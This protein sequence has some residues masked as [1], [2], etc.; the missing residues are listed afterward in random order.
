[1]DSA[2]QILSFILEGDGRF[3]ENFSPE[4]KPF[5]SRI[6]PELPFETRFFTVILSEDGTTSFV[7]TGKIV[8]VSSETATSYAEK[9]WKT[10]QD[11]GFIDEY[12]YA[13]EHNGTEIMIVFIDCG[14]QL[15]AANSFL[16]ISAAISLT[17]YII[18]SLL[19]Y[20]LSARIVKPI[21]DSYEKQRDAVD[22]G[23]YR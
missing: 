15:N 19:L 23:V 20:I 16:L 17:G 11:K 1:M 6:S 18:V 21:S 5:S 7:D 22:F 3:P 13:V 14:R 8:A 2:D 4:N 12:R 9:V 10:Q